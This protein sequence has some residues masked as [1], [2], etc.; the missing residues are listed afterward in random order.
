MKQYSCD[1]TQAPGQPALAGFSCT[2]ASP[3]LL[4]QNTN[5]TYRLNSHMRTA[6]AA[7]L[8]GRG[9][10]WPQASFQLSQ[11]AFSYSSPNPISCHMLWFN[12]TALI[13]IQPGNRA[14]PYHSALLVLSHSPVTC[15]SHS[16]QQE[17]KVLFILSQDCL[18]RQPQPKAWSSDI[19]IKIGKLFWPFC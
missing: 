18:E 7:K 17:N 13:Q 16:S 6:L 3:G 4:S 10:A 14:T 5:P 1:G 19:K 9:R 15:S 2:A 8:A 11:R 12:H